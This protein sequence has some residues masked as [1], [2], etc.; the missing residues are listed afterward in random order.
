MRI[1]PTTIII[2]VLVM[3]ILLE[4]RSPWSS[5]RGYNNYIPSQALQMVD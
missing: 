3:R 2:I 4:R 5:S 1:L